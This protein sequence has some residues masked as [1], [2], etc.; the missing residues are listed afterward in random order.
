M[1]TPLRIV[2]IEI[3]QE[4][5]ANQIADQEVLNGGRGVR[6]R[7]D[8]LKQLQPVLVFRLDFGE[9]S[10]E[11]IAV[12]AVRSHEVDDDDLAAVVGEIVL[13]HAQIGQRKAGR[14][15]AGK[16]TRPQG[17][18]HNGREH[19]QRHCFAHGSHFNIA[20]RWG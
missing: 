3:K 20:G 19:K 8:D 12:R 18:G 1:S 17:S 7:V 16:L 11:R 6:R 5:L 4:K 10:G 14:A 9:C 13:S 15:A 2:E